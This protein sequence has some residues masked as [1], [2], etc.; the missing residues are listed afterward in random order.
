MKTPNISYE[1]DLGSSGQCSKL[2]TFGPVTRF[3][4]CGGE[5]AYKWQP[6][7]E[8]WSQALSAHLSPRI[9]FK[10]EASTAPPHPLHPPYSP[11]QG[12]RDHGSR[13]TYPFPSVSCTQTRVLER[14]Q[15]PLG[16]RRGK[17]RAWVSV[18]VCPSR[19]SH[20]LDLSLW[21]GHWPG[22][23]CFLI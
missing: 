9:S 1:T 19:L 21:S 6:T 15:C 20:L 22:R 8:S 10:R 23:G 3:G 2:R 4:E 14:P 17:G 11:V 16:G 13:T 18:R 12:E 5:V 7:W